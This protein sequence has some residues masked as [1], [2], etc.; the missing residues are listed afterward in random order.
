MANKEIQSRFKLKFETSG[1][2]Q[3]QKTVDKLSEALS[4]KAIGAGM[5]AL[6]E[7]NEAVL[8][9]LDDMAKKA[10]KVSREQSR[11]GGGGGGS[12]RGGSGGAGAGSGGGSGGKGRGAFT[13]GLAQGATGSEYIERGPGIGR[14]LAGRAV[15]GALRTGAGVASGLGNTSFNGVAGLQQA[16]SAVSPMLAGIMGNAVAAVQDQYG[17]QNAQMGLGG[18]MKM[19]SGVKL[20]NMDKTQVTQLA[21]GAG[22]S[23]LDNSAQMANRQ[24]GIRAAIAAQTLGVS[25]ASTSGAFLRAGRGKGGIV[26]AEGR[27]GKALAEAIE[28]GFS[29]GFDRSEVSDF[30]KNIATG[31]ADFARTGISINPDSMMA[32]T[33]AI[34]GPITGGARAGALGGGLVQAGQRIGSKGVS[35][36]SEFM[37]LQTMAGYKGDPGDYMA[38]R[39]RLE[40]GEGFTD[41]NFKTLMGRV[42]RGAGGGEAG[43]QQLINFFG[44]LG[45]QLSAT[46]AFDIQANLEGTATPEQQKKFAEQKKKLRRGPSDAMRSVTGKAAAVAALA[47]GQQLAASM[48]NERIDIGAGLQKSVQ[49]LEKVQMENTKMFSELSPAINKLTTD[50]L[51]ATR[52]INET[53]KALMMALEGGD[54][55]DSAVK[56]AVNMVISPLESLSTAL[57]MYSGVIKRAAGAIPNTGGL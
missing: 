39:R 6:A 49:N 35:N 2:P 57:E 36:T 25:D 13:Q 33:K 3:V 1:A 46:E 23:A 26:G 24:G 42:N 19:P 12:G 4:P 11:I 20:G 51:T 5:E 44:D 53:A 45:Q 14:Q 52:A 32:L 47:P 7:A 41:E 10:R 54:V 8:K 40:S 50:M 43:Q 27:G 48:S 28:G 9:Q 31:Q 30:L 55:K 18:S 38:A 29:A 16:V 22:L 34:T 21:T 37:L 56:T 15:G 17:F